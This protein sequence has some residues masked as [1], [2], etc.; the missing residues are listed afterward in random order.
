MLKSYWPIVY[1][2]LTAGLFFGMAI[3]SNANETYPAVDSADPSS[4]AVPPKS[5]LQKT[6]PKIT[7]T[8]KNRGK[9]SETGPKT[10][11]WEPNPSQNANAQPEP[12][13]PEP[14]IQDETNNL[15]SANEGLRSEVQ[16]LRNQL[17]TA[18]DDLRTEKAQDRSEPIS[19]PNA[20]RPSEVSTA[21]VPEKIIEQVI[22]ENSTQKGI[23]DA[24]PPKQIFALSK[25]LELVEEIILHHGR[26]YDYRNHTTHDLSRILSKLNQSSSE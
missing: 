21:C 22:V 23:F 5:Q 14:E 7:V 9:I 18:L 3:D 25:R 17:K 1:L 20:A 2:A 11:F 10:V 16:M 13:K 12:P 4:M 15:K 8:E 19:T 6:L 26:A 24:V